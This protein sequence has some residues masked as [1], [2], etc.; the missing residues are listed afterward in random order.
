MSRYLRRCPSV[1]AR[2]CH[3]NNHAWNF[4]ALIVFFALKVSREVKACSLDGNRPASRANNT[5]AKLH[6]KNMINI[7]GPLQTT[8]RIQ[9]SIDRIKVS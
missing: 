3:V 6:K 2:D 8:D 9:R 4:H 7:L 1:M 5:T